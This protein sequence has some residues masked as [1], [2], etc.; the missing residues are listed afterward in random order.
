MIRLIINSKTHTGIFSMSLR[1]PWSLSGVFWKRWVPSRNQSH[2]FSFCSRTSFLNITVTKNS[3]DSKPAASICSATDSIVSV[4]M[5]SAQR[6]WL[7]SRTVVSMKRTSLM[8]G[9]TVNSNGKSSKHARTLGS[10]QLH[11]GLL[12][13]VL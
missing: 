12:T 8:F 6:L 3:T 7:P 5:F 10:C 9:S 11:A 1:P 2:A 4:R 13:L